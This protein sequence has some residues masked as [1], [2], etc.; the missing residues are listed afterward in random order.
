MQS[1]ETSQDRKSE[2]RRKGC[3]HDFHKPMP[4]VFKTEAGAFSI[5]HET[6]ALIK[7]SSEA[8]IVN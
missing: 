8:N 7:I 1:P 4:T 6:F 2:R 5:V 3:K